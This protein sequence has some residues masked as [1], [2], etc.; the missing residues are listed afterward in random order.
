MLINGGGSILI[1]FIRQPFKTKQYAFIVPWNTFL[2][3]GYI[4][5]DEIIEN[6][7][8][9]QNFLPHNDQKL[10]DTSL[11]RNFIDNHQFDYAYTLSSQIIRQSL[12]IDKYDLPIKFIYLSSSSTR[13]YQ[14]VLT[15]VLTG[16]QI[17]SNLIQIHLSISIE[18]IYFLK[19]FHAQTN[20]IYEYRWSRRNAY[21]QNVHGLAEAIGICFCFRFCFFS[22][23]LLNQ[24]RK[25]KRYNE[26]K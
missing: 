24:K 4:Y 20:L 17:D 2:H 12:S 16:N 18:G 13:R 1:Q 3:I 19:T 10:W 7:Q 23:F 15:I 25:R 21:D 11:D 22:F 6:I 8:C 9:Y 14:S 5:I 26:L